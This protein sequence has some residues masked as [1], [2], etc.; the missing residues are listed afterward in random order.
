MKRIWYITDG[1]FE[2]QTGNSEVTQRLATARSDY[3]PS[4]GER[5]GGSV[6]GAQRPGFPKGAETERA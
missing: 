5:K 2:G 3:Q 6:T 4:V 1:G